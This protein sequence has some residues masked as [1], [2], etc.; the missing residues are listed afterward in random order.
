LVGCFE[1]VKRCFGTLKHVTPHTPGFNRT[2]S[3]ETNMGNEMLILEDKEGH[4]EPIN[5]H[6]PSTKPARWQSATPNAAGLKAFAPT[7]YKLFATGNVAN[8]YF[9]RSQSLKASTNPLGFQQ[10]T[11]AKPVLSGTGFSRF[12]GARQDA[13][14]GVAGAQGAPPG[15]RPVHVIDDY[16]FNGTFAPSSLKTR[17]L[18]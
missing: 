12:S 5:L 10:R 16:D 13:S 14:A 11:P 3:P 1:E 15:A 6:P 4:Y 7:V 18:L 9:P 8:S 2:I 17:L